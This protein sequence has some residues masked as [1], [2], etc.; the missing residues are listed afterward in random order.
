MKHNHCV[1]C[2]TLENL[3]QHHLVPKSLGGSQDE[4]N[5]LTLCGSCHAKAHQVQAD[6]RHSQLTKKALQNKKAQG[7]CVGTV[8]FGY[9]L[10]DDGDTLIEDRVEQKTIAVIRDYRQAGLSLRTIVSRLNEQ[11]Y[12]SRTGKPLGLTQVARIANG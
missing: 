1:A 3:H 5:L 4:S 11:G 2:G 10:A 9:C 6:W 7:G 12:V 8:N